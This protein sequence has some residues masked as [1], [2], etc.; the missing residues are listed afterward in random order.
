MACDSNASILISTD[1][2]VRPTMWWGPA[3]RGLLNFAGSG[4]ADRPG[5]TATGS[6]SGSAR[7]GLRFRQRARV[8][9]VQVSAL[10]S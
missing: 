6:G 7:P 1:K 5:S 9:P 3:K 2:A 8:L 4:F 10:V